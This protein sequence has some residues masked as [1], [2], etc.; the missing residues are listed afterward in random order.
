[1]VELKE[2]LRNKMQ[3]IKTQSGSKVSKVK[4]KVDQREGEV[5]GSLLGRARMNYEP[6]IARGMIVSLY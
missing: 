1:M 6:Q 3:F 5:E 2:K 4:G